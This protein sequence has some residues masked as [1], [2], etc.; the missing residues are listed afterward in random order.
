MNEIGKCRPPNGQLHELEKS[1]FRKRNL[2]R[3]NKSILF[4]GRCPVQLCCCTLKRLG[5]TAVPLF[6][7]MSKIRASVSAVIIIPDC[8]VFISFVMILGC[9]WMFLAMSYFSKYEFM[10][11][12]SRLQV[13]ADFLLSQKLLTAILLQ[14]KSIMPVVAASILMRISIA[15]LSASVFCHDRKIGLGPS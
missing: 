13:G 9:I 7:V 14:K 4:C 5:P 1:G 2:I 11:M 8:H 10:L 15:K 6:L 12:K 3:K